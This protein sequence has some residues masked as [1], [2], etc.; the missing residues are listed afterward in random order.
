MRHALVVGGSVAVLLV[1]ATTASAA[2]PQ[3]K[4]RYSVVGSTE[5]IAAGGTNRFNN[6][7][8]VTSAPYYSHSN[9][10]L[11]VRTFNGD[12]TGRAEG[13]TIS[14]STPLPSG[15]AHTPG[16][17]SS[18][19]AFNFTY[20]VDKDGAVVTEMVAGTFS[21]AIQTG[22][23]AGQTYTESPFELI[24][25]V[26]GDKKNIAFRTTAPEVETTNYSNGDVRE[27]I[28][29]RSRTLAFIG[30]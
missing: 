29:N 23:R 19:F 22:P 21:G 16:V 1:G 13:S 24:G 7:Q 4:G 17:S 10:V 8:Q 5:C 9:S 6:N 20:S 14:I 18:T 3:L 27:Q 11:A 25:Q 26:S 30:E 28:C 15:G 2:P 12:G